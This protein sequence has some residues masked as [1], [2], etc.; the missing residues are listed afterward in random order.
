MKT[1]YHFNQQNETTTNILT[2]EN[3]FYNQE[4]FA[5][6]NNKKGR[7][8]KGSYHNAYNRESLGSIP[9]RSE[10][11]LFKDNLCTNKLGFNSQTIRFCNTQE[12][13]YTEE[14]T[15]ASTNIINNDFSYNSPSFSSKGYGGF[16]SKTERFTESKK[17]FEDKYF[18]GPGE[19]QIETKKKSLHYSSLFKSDTQVPFRKKL[20]PGPGDY[21]I[22]QNYTFHKKK[23][24][25]NFSSSVKDEICEKL[26][27]IAIEKKNSIKKIKTMNLIQSLQ[28]IVISI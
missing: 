2:I 7:I 26:K 17:E 16:A 25:G 10:N 14:S 19:H 9:G 28:F 4:K 1:N 24:S 22:Q 27:E 6:R 21:N 18:P 15:T 12:K 23:S 13:L 20:S 11:V 5:L 8:F 3:K